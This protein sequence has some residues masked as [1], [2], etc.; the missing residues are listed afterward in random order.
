MQTRL[1]DATITALIEEGYARTT[2][3]EV[4][5]RAGVTR[6]AL[7][8]HFAS[9]SALYAAAL[10]RLYGDLTAGHAPSPVRDRAA[11]PALVRRMADVTQRRE[12]KAIIEIW[13]AARNDPELRVE[14]APAIER[15][16]EIFDPAA[17]PALARRIGASPKAAAFYALVLE[18]TIGMALG[19]AVSPT[20]RPVAHEPLVIALLSE[21]AAKV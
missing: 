4:C 21:L 10:E 11:L 18:A 12:F 6:G 15:L 14:V 13:L 16:S 1:V 8:H 9:L 3:S 19:R 2:A 5:A 17:N 20:N 7:H